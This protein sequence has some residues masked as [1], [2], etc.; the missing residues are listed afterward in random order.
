MSFVKLDQEHQEM[1]DDLYESER[2][3]L[4][5]IAGFCL[6]LLDGLLLVKLILKKVL[7]LYE[8]L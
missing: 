7:W 6:P 4:F 5:S 3:I 1:A 2:K 8:R